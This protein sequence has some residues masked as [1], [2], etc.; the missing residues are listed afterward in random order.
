MP[1]FPVEMYGWVSAVTSGLT[2]MPTATS[3]RSSAAIVAS[4]SSSSSDSTLRWP[5]RARTA[6]RSSSPAFPTPLKTIRSGSKPAANARVISPA[7]TMSAPAPRSR[8]SRRTPSVLL[9]LTA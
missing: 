6:W 8:S 1:L 4:R 5:R 2:R 3:V 7:D 9:A